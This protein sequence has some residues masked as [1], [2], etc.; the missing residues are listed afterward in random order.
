MTG[1][2]QNYLGI[3][4]YSDDTGGATK[5]IGFPGDPIGDGLG[6]YPLSYPSGFSDYG[7]VVNP[8]ASASIAFRSGTTSGKNLDI[9]KDGGAWQTAFFGTSWV[10][11]YNYSPANGEQ[12]L[13]RVIDFF[14][15]CAPPSGTLHIGSIQLGYR[16]P[17]ADRYLVLSGLNVLDQDSQGVEAAAVAV[18]WTLPDSSTRLQ[19]VDTNP[20]GIALFRILSNQ[21]GV[22]Q[23]CVTDVTKSGYLY[24]PSQNG[25][26]CDTINIP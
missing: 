15:G 13:G 7:D 9:D 22:H 23:L 17:G 18:E 8:G 12:I 24:D 5:K 11:V 4:N 10:P 25:E 6:P 20:R 21:S 19:Q 14:G 16:S 2:G 3:G 26:T 1:F